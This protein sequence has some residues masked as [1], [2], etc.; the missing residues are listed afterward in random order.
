MA[1]YHLHVR[2]GNKASEGAAGKKAR[3]LLRV[4]PYAT[5]KERVVDGANVRV[6]EIDKAAELVYAESGNMP[7]WAV[8]NPVFFWDASDQYERANGCT[9]REVEVALP[10]ELAL[11]DQKNLARA[12]ARELAQVAE[13]VTPYTLAIHRQD[14]EHPN[15]LHTHILVSDRIF[16]GLDRTPETFF[17]RYT[18]KAPEK[19]GARK[20]EDRRAKPDETWTDRIRPLWQDMANQALQSAGLEA[21]IDHRTLQE[22]RLDVEEQVAQEQDPQKRRA[23]KEL[24]DALD[25]P[26]QPKRGR[27]LTHAGPQKAPDRAALFIAYE[28]AKTARQAV[29]ADLRAAEQEAQEIAQ[30]ARILERAQARHQQR[31]SEDRQQLRRRWLQRQQDRRNRQLDALTAAEQRP[32]IRHPQQEQWR[33]YRERILTEAYNQQIAQTLGR[34]VRIE[35][36]PEGLRIH[37]RQMGLMDYGDRITAGMGG[38]DREIAAMLDIA[39]AKGW[40]CLDITGS[41]AFREKLGRAALD[42]GFTLADANL[43][44]R[45]QERQQQEAAMREAMLRRQAP[46]LGQWMHEHPKRAALLKTAG[47]WLPGA[48]SG[49][50]DWSERAW[51]AAQAWRIGRYGT[52]QERQRL[53]KQGSPLQRDCAAD[54]LEAA[55]RARAQ[56]G[57]ELRIG[58]K[59]PSAVPGGL[60]WH[61]QGEVTPEQIETLAQAI[62][63]RQAKYGVS[64]HLVVTFDPFVPQNTRVLVYEHL[65]RRGLQVQTPSGHGDKKAYETA[66][67]RLHTHHADGSEQQWVIDRRARLAQAAREKAEREAQEKLRAARKKLQ[68]DAKALGWEVGLYGDNEAR[69][70]RAQA[71]LENAKRL[72][73]TDISRAYAEGERAGRKEAALQA[74]REAGAALQDAY[75]GAEDEQPACDETTWQ[76]VQ[77]QAQR[78]VEEAQKLGIAKDEA[79]AALDAGRQAVLRQQRGEHGPRNG[80]A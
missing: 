62:K 66:Q 64:H 67:E 50:Q 72:G 54:G 9:Y 60:V 27:V 44:A 36:T 42:A 23:L 37:N 46:I 74:C 28:Q 12:F 47:R 51:E 53:H 45:I 59:A 24:A 11:E 29:L 6:L 61:S 76:E 77:A 30:R 80:M 41:D 71:L 32:G 2:S 63:D 75:G 5:A 19:G 3:Y 10:E 48:P 57:L 52:A 17:K 73:V 26:P 4:G 18:S 39:R 8:D 55:W 56:K 38:T 1:I 43:Q 22:Q 68:E 33:A 58:A 70:Q 7:S 13:G 25:R 69:N 34:W 65:L 21:R 15:R 31:S 79:Q 40:T 14:P 78:A 35:R 49:V 16:D 20:T